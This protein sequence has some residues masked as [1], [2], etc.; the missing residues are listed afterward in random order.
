MVFSWSSIIARVVLVAVVV[1]ANQ[2]G[3][4]GYDS[5]CLRDTEATCGAVGS[6][7]SIRLDACEGGLVSIQMDWD[8]H[9]GGPYQFVV[10]NFTVDGAFGGTDAQFIEMTHVYEQTGTYNPT[11]T[12]TGYF[13][14]NISR[15][16]I[17]AEGMSYHTFTIREDTCSSAPTM[18]VGLGAAMGAMAAMLS[19]LVL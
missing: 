13:S 15:P 5:P 12:I 8:D 19:Y 10:K 16:A 14:N 2:E 1:T 11:Y 7:S 18:L 6:N 9:G 4:P 17:I 3:I